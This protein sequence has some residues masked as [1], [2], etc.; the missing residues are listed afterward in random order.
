M[1]GNS[2]TLI[3]HQVRR[4][5]ARGRHTRSRE[6][7]VRAVV[8][9]GRGEHQGD[10]ERR[11]I[12]AGCHGRRCRGR[13][14]GAVEGIPGPRS[15]SNGL[16][17]PCRGMVRASA[18]ARCGAPC[19][20]GLALPGLA[21]AAD[22]PGSPRP[23][24]LLGATWAGVRA[25][26]AR[27]SGGDHRRGPWA[28]NGAGPGCLSCRTGGTCGADGDLPNTPITRD[29]SSIEFPDRTGSR[30]RSRKRVE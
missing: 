15:R 6:M 13:A 9:R 12:G 25:A 14:Y 2:I 7:P 29:F 17:R 16:R 28:R 8:V 30:S 10:A 26:L 19:A 5:R 1:Y 4:W 20:L 3:L 27:D 23:G 21:R 11:K 18:E 22:G 24:L